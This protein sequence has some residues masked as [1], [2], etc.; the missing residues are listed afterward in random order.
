M[1]YNH[2][3]DW[4]IDHSTRRQA[5]PR[6]APDRLRAR[7]VGFGVRPRPHRARRRCG[8]GRRAAQAPRRSTGRGSK[9]PQGCG[10]W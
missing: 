9:R 4:F 5:A 2:H 7:A 6:P 1:S 3:H 8:V 10:W